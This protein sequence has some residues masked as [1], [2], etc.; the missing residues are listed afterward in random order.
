MPSASCDQTSSRNGSRACSCTADFILSRKSSSLSCVRAAPTT[1]KLSGSSRRY[2]R[3]YSAGRSFFAVRSPDAPKMTRMQG[4][5]RRRTW[6]PSSSGFCSSTGATSVATSALRQHGVPAELVA[7]RR[8]HLRGERLV[9]PRGE[10]REERGR[11]HRDR[12][13]LG[14]RL[15]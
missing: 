3:A 15:V 14:D 11:D 13:V 7:Q 5:G 4:S 2:V 10:A 1:A 8:V 12:Y 6:R 9:L